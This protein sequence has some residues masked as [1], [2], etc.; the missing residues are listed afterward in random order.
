MGLGF[1]KLENTE[2]KVV[3]S[4]GE[5]NNNVVVQQEAPFD[6]HSNELIALVGTICLIKIIELIYFLYKVHTKT[7]KKKY[8]NN[9][10]QV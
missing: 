6:I 9:Q 7:I 5:V 2:T 10:P 1:S 3:D 8:K 4:T